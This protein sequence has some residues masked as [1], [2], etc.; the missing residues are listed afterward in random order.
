MNEHADDCALGADHDGPC[1]AILE[2]E[3]EDA[4]YSDIRRVGGT[5]FDDLGYR[6]GYRDGLAERSNALDEVREDSRNFRRALTL[7]AA[8]LACLAIAVSSQQDDD[9]E[10]RDDLPRLRNR[11]PRF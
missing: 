8:G 10:V 9:E 6:A 5:V 4:P 11:S 7:L 1:K 2:G 3:G